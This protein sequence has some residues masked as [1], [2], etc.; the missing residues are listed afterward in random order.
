MPIAAIVLMR[1]SRS[2]AGFTAGILPESVRTG[3][4]LLGICVRG[5]LLIGFQEQSVNIQYLNLGNSK[6]AATDF[7]NC[8]FLLARP[9]RWA[10][11]LSHA[12]KTRGKPGP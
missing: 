4:D 8:L 11:G 1:E 9:E 12:P 2:P 5:R 7:C 10:F 3:Y 6:K